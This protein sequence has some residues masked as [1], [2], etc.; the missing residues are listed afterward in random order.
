VIDHQK[1]TKENTQ[2]LIIAALVFTI[3]LEITP[4]Q[5]QVVILSKNTRNKLRLMK[6]MSYTKG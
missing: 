3:L 6:P 1:D 4:L 2:I 5:A